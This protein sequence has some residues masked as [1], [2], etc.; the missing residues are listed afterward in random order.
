MKSRILTSA[1]LLSLLVSPAVVPSVA[2]A[3]GWA[4]IDSP[5]SRTLTA[6]DA[7]SNTVIAV[8]Y[9]GTVIW[10]DDGGDDWSSGDS[11]VSADLYGVSIINADDAVAVGAS[12]TVIVTDDGGDSWEDA[13]LSGLSSTEEGYDLYA[14]SMGSSTVGFAVGENGLVLKTTD[15]GEVWSQIEDPSDDNTHF[16]AV[17]AYSATVAWIAGDAGAVYKTANGGTSWTTESSSTSDDIRQI[18]F[19]DSSHGW[20]VGEG[21]TLQRTTNGGTTW[22]DLTVDDLS[23][24]DAI[25]SVSFYDEDN[26]ILVSA[27]HDLLETDDG[28]DSWSDVNASTSSLSLLSVIAVSSVQWWGVGTSGDLARF[29]TTAPSKPTNFDVAGDNDAVVDTTPTFS[30]TA[31]ADGESS[32]DRYYFKIDGGSYANIGNVTEKTPSSALS[33][34]EHTAYLYAVD[35]GENASAVASVQFT[36]DADSTGG[37]SP[38][39][40]EITPT[41]AIRDYAVTF[42]VRASDDGEVESCDL[43]IDGENARAMVPRQDVAY[44]GY[45]FE[46]TGEYEMYARCTDDDGNKTSG[47]PVTVTV[48]NTS[49]YVTPGNIIKI[50]CTGDVYVNDPCTAVY[51]YGKD[52]KRHA[53]PNESTFKTW[54]SDYDDLVILSASAMA[55][56]PLGRNVIIRPGNG[57]IKFSTS[58]VY[59]TS[60]LGVL[61]PIASAAIAEALFGT[62]WTSDITVVSDVFFSNYRIGSTVESSADYSAS[63]AKTITSS[64]DA[65]F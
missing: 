64:I 38:D 26:G 37:D 32:I 47:D 16:H 49:A 65:T 15:G 33:N 29:D 28:G 23:D 25:L 11:D 17:H 1:L 48:S 7:Y 4:E 20:A 9:D 27:D 36:I 57:M 14:V 31:P 3:S 24:S 46:E 6:V 58:T 12:G 18:T 55:D 53:F 63:S 45:V 56:I 41:T 10:T 21:T 39:V 40:S 44:V 51:Y 60:Y 61:R 43:Y 52:G 59:A 19:S 13:S 35:E 50:G 5:T 22:S 42:S 8:G 62:N 34:G 54:L 30:W 2:L